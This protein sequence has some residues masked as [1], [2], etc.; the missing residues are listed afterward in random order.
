MQC[1]IY[2][3]RHLK[4]AVQRITEQRRNAPNT[5]NLTPYTYAYSPHAIEMADTQ[6]KPAV[7][8]VKD[9]YQTMYIETDERREIIYLFQIISI[10]IKR[11]NTLS[12]KHTI[13]TD[14]DTI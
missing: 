11:G 8:V 14:T 10:A 1:L 12:F 13:G 5:R 4:P 2:N 7:E 3:P 6:D 9:I